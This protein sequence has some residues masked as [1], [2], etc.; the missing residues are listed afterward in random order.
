MAVFET[1]LQYTL[2]AEGVRL[3]KEGKV[4]DTGYS[5]RKT[6]RGGETRWGI[7]APLARQYGFTPGQLTIGEAISV[8]RRHFWDLE[9]GRYH[10]SLDQIEPQNVATKVFDC[11]VNF[12]V[13]GG[14]IVVQRALGLEADGKFGQKTMTAVRHAC[15]TLEGSLA[16]VDA[17]AEKAA[18]A[19][20][21]IVIG[22][23]RKRYGNSVIEDTQLANLLGWIRR[24]VRKPPLPVL[25]R[26]SG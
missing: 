26:G 17:I 13:A 19:Y 6:D 5:N 11:L 23:L 24:A 22:D 21:L 3:S 15:A 12:G 8:Y 4:L 1:A 20:C 10:T 2:P 14:T 18:D 7:S 16:L 25:L 9:A